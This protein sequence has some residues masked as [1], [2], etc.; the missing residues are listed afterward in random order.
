MP[1]EDKDGEEGSV[2]SSGGLVSEREHQAR[3]QLQL[4]QLMVDYARHNGVW[5]GGRLDDWIGNVERNDEH[6]NL[7]ERIPDDTESPQLEGI[8][9]TL[10]SIDGDLRD[11]ADPADVEDSL[12][13]LLELVR[14]VLSGESVPPV[15]QLVRQWSWVFMTVH[16]GDKGGVKLPHDLSAGVP[17]GQARICPSPRIEEPELD[18]EPE[19]QLGPKIPDLPS[20]DDEADVGLM[21]RYVP[22]T[23]PDY[24]PYVQSP[25]CP[26]VDGLMWVDGDGHWV[27]KVSFAVAS[28]YNAE[29][30]SRE[31]K[32]RQCGDGDTI[33]S[34]DTL[35]SQA[36]SHLGGS[37]G[38]SKPH[39]R[40][41]LGGALGGTQHAVGGAATDPKV[42]GRIA[43]PMARTAPRHADTH[44]PVRIGGGCR[45]PQDRPPPVLQ[46]SMACLDLI[47]SV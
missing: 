11:G 6:V 23:E 19:D 39:W 7:L 17:D 4:A 37:Y 20:S 38:G 25:Y 2:A 35:L 1:D 8:F 31:R 46:W 15:R 29:V 26:F 43:D 40:I 32:R 14:G 47:I 10:F 18:L 42:R 27:R 41:H 22:Y 9:W 24:V 12:D 34:G 28:I 16:Y 44:Q 13:A 21:G 36:A 33:V 3:V 45:P 5:K 30:P